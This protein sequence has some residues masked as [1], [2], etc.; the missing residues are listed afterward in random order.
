MEYLPQKS[1]KGKLTKDRYP[2]KRKNLGEW[3]KRQEGFF[4]RKEKFVFAV[5]TDWI[6]Y[7]GHHE[8]KTTYFAGN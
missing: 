6:I 5:F 7:V 1:G 3:T 2:L 4:Y 8:N